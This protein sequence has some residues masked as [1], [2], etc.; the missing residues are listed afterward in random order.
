MEVVARHLQ[1]E[2]IKRS[3]AAEQDYFGRSAFNRYYYA[4]FLE[5]KQV[6]GSLRPEWAGN[7]AHASIPEML[8]GRVVDELKRGRRQAQRLSDWEVASLCEKGIAAAI[9]LA[10]LM[11][12]GRAIRTTADYHPEVRVEFSGKIGFKLNAVSVEMA[13]AWPHR[14]RAFLEVT[15]NAWRQIDE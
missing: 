5:V 14:A 15:A 3:I 1:Q 13:Q 7:L 4:T 8:R 10:R 6:L 11:E 2:A 12:E 9:D